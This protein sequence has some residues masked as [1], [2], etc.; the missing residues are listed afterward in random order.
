MSFQEKQY[1]CDMQNSK[2][3]LLKRIKKT[4]TSVVPEATVILYG[5][6]ARGEE[7]IGSDIDL[8]VLLDKNEITWEDEKKISFLLYDIEFDMGIIIS[9]LILSKKDWEKR[10]YI[11]P[12]YENV[13]NEGVIL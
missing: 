3:I 1:L 8:L 5:S 6:Y 9:P 7:K 13:R 12:F 11:T 10:H 4:I 2:E